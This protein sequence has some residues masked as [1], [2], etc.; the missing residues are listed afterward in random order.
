LGD[1]IANATFWGR[2]AAGQRVAVGSVRELFGRL[3]HY[4]NRRRKEGGSPLLAVVGHS[5]GGM[6]VYA[7]LAQ[8]LID[9]ASAPVGKVTP[10][11]A[12]MVLL[13]NPAIEGARYLPIYDLVNSASF[14]DRRTKQ[15]PIFICAQADNDQPVGMVFPLGNAGHAL[16]E[17]TIGDLE[18]EC[19]THALGFVPSFRT[20]VLAGPTGNDPFVLVPPESA[21]ANPF[22][23]VRAAKEVIDEHGGIWQTPFLRFCSSIFFQHVQASKQGP[24][25]GGASLAPSDGGGLSG[26]LVAFAKSIGQI[27]PDQP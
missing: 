10:E 24:S 20:H 23:I 2:Q 15:L 9:A 18:K 25:G 1:A 21:Q 5:F 7:A 4:R 22:W 6:I 16:A 14:E 12:D 8:S 11:F 3:R 19:V 26:E 17:A 13:V 27:K